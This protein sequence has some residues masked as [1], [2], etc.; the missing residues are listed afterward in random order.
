MAINLNAAQRNA[1]TLEVYDLLMS[2][3]KITQEE[4]C[5][6]VGISRNTFKKYFAPMQESMLE[7]EK[8]LQEIELQDYANK[9]H[10]QSMEFIELINRTTND[11]GPVDE[12]LEKLKRINK[13]IDTLSYKRQMAEY[14]RK[15][16]LD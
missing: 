5:K 2:G 12:S 13:V 1:Q 11:S 14:R 9:L 7:F 8:K 6:Q 3:I 10:N 4:A 16:E 15:Q